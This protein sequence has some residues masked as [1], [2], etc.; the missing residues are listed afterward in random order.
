VIGA[1]VSCFNPATNTRAQARSDAG[2]RYAVPLLPPGLYFVRAS[3]ESYQAQEVQELTLA[4]AGSI[5]LD[6]RLR[7]L[8]DVWES[9]QYRSV[10]L[11]GTKAIVNFYGPDVDTS[12]SSF[13]EAPRAAAGTIESTVS[14]VI[15]PVSVRDLPLAG[16]DVY[17]MLVTQPGVTADTATSRGL[18]VSVNGQRPSSSNFLLDGVENNNYLVTGPLTAIAPEAVQ[19]Y[20]ISTNN[21]S[22]EYGRSA[23]F[24]A[25]AVTLSGGTHW[26]GLGYL[27]F[28]NTV[29]N[30]NDFQANL[31]G[32]PRAPVH[33]TEPGYQVSG[34]V[35][36]GVFVSS[37]FDALRSRDRAGAVTVLMPSPVVLELAAPSSAAAKLL[38]QFPSP[39]TTLN[40]YAAPVTFDPPVSID[41]QLAL[42]RVDYAPGGAHRLMGRIALAR[43]GRT[44]FIWSPYPAFISGMSNN[45]TSIM[46]GLESALRP[47]WT[48][49]ARV[50]WSSD[51]LHWDRAHP[52]IPTF[53]TQLDGASV[54]LP[55][56]PAL[57]A[58]R[59]R[60]RAWELLDN[61]TRVHGR[62][63]AKVG[64][65]ALLRSIGGYLT[66]G[67]DGFYGYQDP[68]AFAFDE[69]SAF[70]AGIARGVTPA[71]VPDTSRSYR[72]NQFYLFAQDSFRATRR[73][74]LNYGLRYDSFG[75]PRNTGAVK[76]LVVQFGAGD[77]FAQRLA[78]AKLTL[79]GPGD[80]QVFQ[81]GPQRLGRPL[82]R[83]LQPGRQRPHCLARRLWHLL[84]P[85]L[86]QSL[87]DPAQQ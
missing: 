53:A 14:A 15:D 61:L 67:R 6:L 44:D 73:L 84:R 37:A 26:H 59:N 42:E 65:G 78:G 64:A 63:I 51:D 40:A 77:N 16:R 49:E 27:D 24:V 30:A 1:T 50:S 74:T 38:T 57:Y 60:A 20:R 2:G 41:R 70:A 33:E 17:T 21:F 3:A 81:P 8:H 39:V 71:V 23:G 5:E 43:L 4:V 45:D 86:R 19:E 29:L 87:G 56:S 35:H 55:G 58:F 12:R 46:L 79:P 69:P 32:L 80:Q 10:F 62:H 66:A 75:A 25:N 28:K 7:P 83:R 54:A 48:N 52:E 9:G 68:A 76:D 31:A 47:G 11:P 72:Y 85:A 18:G 36:R 22:A 34:R 82:R 13:V